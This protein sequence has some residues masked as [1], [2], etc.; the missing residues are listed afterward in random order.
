MYVDGTMLVDSGS[1]AGVN[2]FHLDFS[3]NSSNAA[4]GLDQREGVTQDPTGSIYGLLEG[5]S[6]GNVLDGNLT[7]YANIRP[8]SSLSGQGSGVSLDTAIT[9]TSS[10][11]IYGS[12]QG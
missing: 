2:G 1:P 3:D 10:V 6:A 5:G 7:T 12:S 9:A 8:Y 4:L 11:R